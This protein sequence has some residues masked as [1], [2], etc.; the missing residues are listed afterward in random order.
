MSSFFG[1]FPTLLYNL[2]GLNTNQIVVTNLLYRTHLLPSIANNTS[3][4]YLYT[5]KDGETPEIV[6]EKYYGNPEAHWLVMYANNVVDPQFDWLLTQDEF[7][8]YIKAKYG[9]IS[10]AMGKVHH[11]NKVIETIDSKT[12]LVSFNSY[13]ID[14]A[15]NRS[16]VGD[17]TLPYSTYSNLPDFFDVNPKGKFKDGSG[18]TMYIT[19]SITYCY[20]WED[21]QNENKRNIKLIRKEYW[22]QIQ[23]EFLALSKSASPDQYQYLRQIKQV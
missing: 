3:N 20:D 23:A 15:D 19:R 9:S 2:D 5:L 4:Y 17:S 6:A 1:K 8:A 21:A 10:Q 11:Y 18:E 22:P 13:E 14:F 7:N 16:V 12:G